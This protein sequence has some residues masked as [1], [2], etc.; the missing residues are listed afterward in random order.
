[1]YPTDP[2]KALD[3]FVTRR[4]LLSGF[5]LEYSLLLDERPELTN[6]FS[7]DAY[8]QFS[9]AYYAASEQRLGH[10]RLQQEIKRLREH[11][12]LP[13]PESLRYS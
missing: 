9:F 7:F 8:V 3:L 1:M 12:P 10:E 11:L 2:S 5:L 6:L 4:D 13:L